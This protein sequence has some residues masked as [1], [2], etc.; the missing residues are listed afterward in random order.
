[1]LHEPADMVA[2]VEA[3]GPVDTEWYRRV[4]V[5]ARGETSERLDV[6]ARK[7]A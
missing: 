6:V 2:L 7:S 1:M 3:V 5:A 4:A